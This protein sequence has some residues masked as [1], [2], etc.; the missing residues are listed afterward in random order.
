MLSACRSGMLSACRSTFCDNR[1]R[2][3]SI[4]SLKEINIFMSTYSYLYVSKSIFDLDTGTL[5]TGAHDHGLQK[6]IYV[7]CQENFIMYGGHYF[8]AHY[9]I[10]LSPMVSCS[11]LTIKR[12][13]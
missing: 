3:H 7:P 1:E 8:K 9:K 2:L 11:N 6:S 5:M 12:S 13:F 4:G 10:T